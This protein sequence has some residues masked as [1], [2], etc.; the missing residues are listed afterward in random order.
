LILE[1]NEKLSLPQKASEEGDERRAWREGKNIGS[2]F[3]ESK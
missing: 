1:V 2:R 3:W